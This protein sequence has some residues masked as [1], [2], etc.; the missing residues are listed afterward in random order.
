MSSVSAVV[1]ALKLGGS[2]TALVAGAGTKSV[3]EEAAKIKGVEKVIYVE[4]GAYDR[5]LAE[6][7]AP[8]V[9]ENVKKG[10]FTHVLAGHSAFGKN[11][12]P[13]VAALLDS[14]QISDIIGVEGE[15]SKLGLRRKLSF[16]LQLVY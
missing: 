16:S 4:N 13:R 2:V 12:M 9:V 14:Q 7:Y 15:D 5:G 6:N 8:L 10:G 11:L 1:A 3:A